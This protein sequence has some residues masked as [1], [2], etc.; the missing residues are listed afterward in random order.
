MTVSSWR[1]D[2]DEDIA[3]PVEIRKVYEEWSH[4]LAEP[5]RTPYLAAPEYSPI[6]CDRL[7]QWPTIA[8]DNM[9][10]RVTLAGDAAHP[11]TYRKFTVSPVEYRR[12]AF[13][14]A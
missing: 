12:L 14:N 7:G 1:D 3:D 8:W 5:F 11:M 4:K 9:R 10:G 6:W 13:A 2:S